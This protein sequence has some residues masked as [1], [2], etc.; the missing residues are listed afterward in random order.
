MNDLFDDFLYDDSLGLDDGFTGTLHDAPDLADDPYAS[1]DL[2]GQQEDDSS[3]M[4][5]T[6]TANDPISFGG[7]EAD[8]QR[9][10]EEN[11]WNQKQAAHA[12]D[13]ENKHLAQASKA[14]Q[15]GDFESAKDHRSTAESWHR[16]GKDYLG[17]VKPTP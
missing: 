12:F 5:N 16:T 6:H 13:E 7:K 2:M 15:N 11:E 3:L 1:Y 17:K 4:G 14:A 8:D 10:K 9:Q